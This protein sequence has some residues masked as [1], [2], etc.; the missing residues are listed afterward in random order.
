MEIAMQRMIEVHTELMRIMTQD[1]VN[2]NSKSLP[3]GMQQVLDDHSRMVQMMSQ[4]MA[5]TNNNL[6]QNNLGTKELRDSA[7]ITLQAFKICG[8]IGHVTKGCCEQCPYCYTS[9]PTG[10]CPMTQVTCFLCDGI[11][12]VPAECYLYPHGAMNE[13]TGQ[14]WIVPNAGKDP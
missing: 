4:I 7:E 10:E 9:H 2:H 12:H 14:T 5:N 6:S 11:N 1:M 3:P 8:E 13:S